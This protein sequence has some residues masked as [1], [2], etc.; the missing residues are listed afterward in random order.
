MHVAIQQA[1]EDAGNAAAGPENYISIGA[2]GRGHSFVLEGIFFV[3]ATDFQPRH[4]IRV[5]AAAVGE[6]QA[7]APL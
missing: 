6:G 5:I 1:Y 2:A 4:D 3:F 7:I